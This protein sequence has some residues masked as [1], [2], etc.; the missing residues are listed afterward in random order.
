[1]ESL[2]LSLPLIHNS[3]LLKNYGYYYECFDVIKAA[4]HI[5]T[6][7]NEHKKNI[8]E[9]DKKNKYLLNKF[10]PNNPKNINIYNSLINNI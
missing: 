10:S 4:E 9:Y 7:L 5:G 2:Y 8:V 1:M 3:K 6:I